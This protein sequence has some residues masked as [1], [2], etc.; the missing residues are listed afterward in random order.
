MFELQ[1]ETCNTQ[2]LFSSHS[3]V[4][5]LTQLSMIVQNTY[6]V[7][8]GINALMKKNRKTPKITPFMFIEGYNSTHAGLFLNRY[9]CMIVIL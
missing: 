3:S 1:H 4:V 2:L 8:S 6:S 9:V 7:P 5:N